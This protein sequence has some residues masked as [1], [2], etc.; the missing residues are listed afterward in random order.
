MDQESPLQATIN[1]RRALGLSIGAAASVATALSPG[2][3]SAANFSRVIIDP[4]HGGRDPGSRWYG[5]SEKTLTLDVAKRLSTTLQAKKIPTVLTRTGDS[6]LSLDARAQKSNQYSNAVLVSIHFNA[7][8]NRSIKGIETF[9]YPG[10]SKGRI[11]ASK[12]QRELGNRINTANRGIKAGRMKVLRLSKH[13][14]ILIECSFLSNRWECQRCA[15]S[16]YRQIIAE[17]I[18]EGLL[19]YR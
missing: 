2:L 8:T 13:P 12:V 16:W 6:T 11:L 18:A 19:N 17:E 3:A 9:Y 10:S 15:A 7:H 1:R 14:S 5:I 4:G